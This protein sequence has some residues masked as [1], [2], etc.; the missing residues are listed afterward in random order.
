M[1][2]RLPVAAALVLLLSAL[3]APATAADFTDAAGRHVVLPEHVSRILPAERNAEVMVYA[4]AP[5][6]LVGSSRRL[7]HRARLLWEP[8]DG[9]ASMAATA[10][11]LRAD[12]IIDAGTVT[13]QRAAFADAVMRQTGIPYVLV[14]DSFTRMP[15][16]MRTIGAIIG[17]D[18]RHNREL[19]RYA[20]H[21]IAALRGQLLIEAA[22]GR[23]RVYYARGF[24]GLTTA[25]PGTPAGEAIAEAGA[26]NVA[27]PS[28]PG[29]GE[30]VSPAQ[31]LAWNPEIIIADGPRAYSA[32]RRNRLWR[33]L[34]A[35]RNGRVYLEPTYP[36]GWIEDPSGV[37]RLIGLYW[38]TALFYPNSLQEDMRATTCDFYD[39]FY[40]I[41]LTNG[42]LEKMLRAAGLPPSGTTVPNIEPLVGLGAAPPSTL[43]PSAPT[44][45]PPTVPLTP[46]APS[47]PSSRSTPPPSTS[48][49]AQVPGALPP[50]PP[51]GE[52]LSAKCTLP[53]G[54]GPLDLTPPSET[55]GAVPGVTAPPTSPPGVPPPGRRGRP[56]ARLNTP[57]ALPSAAEP[58][59]G[60]GT[61]ASAAGL[62]YQYQTRP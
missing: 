8:R 9:P 57:G 29:M 55:P 7:G 35:V 61:T 54:T 24:D 10:L 46:S 11:Q 56:A 40:R 20:E 51:A 26:I 62:G 32:M 34:L 22:S 42:Q 16:S 36:F 50:V 48:P 3:A 45:V 25:L 33:G 37:N 27:R 6:K 14:D 21:A 60:S 52:N 18:F 38:L 15:R 12:L 5:D 30:R 13:P 2:F 31:L 44:S 43:T 4:L 59:I 19:W 47:A 1:P 49:S 28:A 39:K 17:A 41:R 23:P 53:G 58:D